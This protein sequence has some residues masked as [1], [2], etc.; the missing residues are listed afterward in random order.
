MRA[1]VRTSAVLL[2]LTLPALARA[3][4]GAGVG[5]IPIV[6]VGRVQLGA[7]TRLNDLYVV[8]T[9]S[10]RS[11]Y[12][13]TVSRISRGGERPVPSGWVDVKRV[14]LVL[15]AR[16]AA[17]IPVE[18]HV[19]AGT[20]PGSYMT[21]LVATT[22]GSDARG[23]TAFGAAAAAKLAFTIPDG[24][25]SALPGWLVPLGAAVLAAALA[26]SAIKRSGVRLR[27][28]RGPNGS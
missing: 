8:N 14:G 28:E 22:V 16:Q 13:I 2:C 19:P 25:G 18:L 24:S 17:W 7:T 20:P 15:E 11:S 23:G 3:D 9:G 10:V 26:V 4:I 5:A 1:F 21:N 27:L 12:R 6:P